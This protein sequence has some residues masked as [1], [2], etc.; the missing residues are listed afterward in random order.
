MDRD[1]RW[2]RVEPAYRLL[3]EGEGL[4][5]ADSGLQALAA[6]YARDENDEFVA[7]TGIGAPVK[8]QDGDV[9]IFMNF[10]ADRARQLT[11]ALTDPA[12]NGFTARQ[13]KLG[14]FVTLTSYGEAY[15]NPVAYAPQKISNGFGEYLASL[16]LTQLRIAETEKYRTS[17][18]SSMVAK[19]RFT[20]AKTA[21]WCHRPK[22][23]LT[24]CSRK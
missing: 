3:V 2:E 4:Y 21:S 16:G 10:R 15:S 12:F 17:P 6:A 19:S 20:P 7:A 13:P 11:T 24:I 14:Q 23:P 5:H 8:M 22:S 9:A 1:K 18:I